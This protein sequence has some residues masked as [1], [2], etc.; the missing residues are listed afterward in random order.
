MIQLLFLGAVL[1]LEMTGFDL[2]R[3]PVTND[4]RED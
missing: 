1:Q 3:L 2:G 4:C